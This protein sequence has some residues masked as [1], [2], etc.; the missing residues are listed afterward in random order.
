MLESHAPADSSIHPAPRSHDARIP[1]VTTIAGAAAWQLAGPGY[2][3]GMAKGV[4]KRCGQCGQKNRVPMNK[5]GAVHKGNCGR[6][7]TALP[8]FDRPIE[9]TDAGVLRTI[10]SSAEMPVL[11]DFWAAWCPPCRMVAPELVKVARERAGDWL[12]VKANTERDP[13]VGSE[14]QISSIPLMAVF[15]DGREV[16]RSAGARPAAAIS[17]FVRQSLAS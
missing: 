13:R 3:E 1:L 12:V 7:G 11:V 2:I 14:H 15:V 10:L 5:L 17:S 9:V 4:I 8:A 6:C 16:G